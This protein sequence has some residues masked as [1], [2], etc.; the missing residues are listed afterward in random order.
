MTMEENLQGVAARLHFPV[1]RHNIHDQ[2]NAKLSLLAMLKTMT[3]HGSS[4]LLL[5]FRVYRIKD[6]KIVRTPSMQTQCCKGPHSKGDDQHRTAP[7][8]ILTR[9]H[10]LCIEDRCSTTLLHIIDLR[11]CI[12]SHVIEIE[13][14]TP[15]FHQIHDGSMLIAGTDDPTNFD[16]KVMELW[17]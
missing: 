5:S 7:A 10:L 15:Y 1:R 4:G 16:P 12:L 9:T 13:G 14:S 6:K 11:S 8:S 2:P 17:R 3:S